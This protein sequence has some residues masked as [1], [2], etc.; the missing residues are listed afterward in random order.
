MM[1]WKKLPFVFQKPKKLSAAYKNRK[2]A[3]Q[4]KLKKVLK[5]QSDAQKQLLLRKK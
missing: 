2:A 1:F 3:A 5:L 4:K